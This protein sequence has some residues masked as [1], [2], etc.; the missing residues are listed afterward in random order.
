MP[1]LP[2]KYRKEMIFGYIWIIDK[3]DQKKNVYDKCQSN[4]VGFFNGSTFAAHPV[5]SRMMYVWQAMHGKVKP[6]KAYP[7][8]IIRLELSIVGYRLETSIVCFDLSQRK[9]FITCSFKKYLVKRSH[10]YT[11]HEQ[12][13]RAF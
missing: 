9:V 7:M 6:S 8:G 12:W 2:L 4:F 1:F 5:D 3:R 10:T 13:M 11:S